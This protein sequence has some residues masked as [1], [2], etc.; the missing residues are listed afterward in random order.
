MTMEGLHAGV[1]RRM[2]LPGYMVV[3]VCGEEQPSR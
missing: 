2:E 3:W 1:D